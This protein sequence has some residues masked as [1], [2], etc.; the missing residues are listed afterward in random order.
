MENNHSFKDLLSSILKRRWYITALVL[1]T[2]ILLVA[3]IMAAI[4]LES[5]ISGEWKELLLLL[6]GAFIG[7]YGK[8]IDYWFSNKETDQLL[9]QKGDEEDDDPEILLAKLNK[10]SVVDLSK[11]KIDRATYTGSG[12]EIDENGDGVIDG[13]DED[14]DGTIDIYFE[15]RQCEHV[16]V[17]NNSDGE[18]ECEKCGLI[19]EWFSKEGGD[20]EHQ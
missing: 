19:K 14:G 1:S 17:D 11:K 4:E 20:Y 9:V 10:T 8:I 5:A 2:F 15:H 12:K 16:W 3:S 7:S 13:V 6:L 18:L